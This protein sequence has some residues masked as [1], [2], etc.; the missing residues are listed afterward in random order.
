[1]RAGKI[2]QL[3]DAEALYERPRTASSASSWARAT[4]SKARFRRRR[5]RDCAFRP[6]SD[7]VRATAGS[8]LPV[9]GTPVTLAIRP[10]EGA[11]SSPSPL[12]RTR[13]RQQVRRPTVEQLIYIGSETH[14]ILTA[15]G[16]QLTAYVMNALLG[17]HGLEI[18]DAVGATCR[19][20]ALLVLED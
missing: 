15:P 6:R 19:P 14:Y 3:G 9:T 16:G 1:M 12:W 20:T 17:S 18:G 13:R 7:A 11:N 8:A 4:S 5:G 10:G 2:E